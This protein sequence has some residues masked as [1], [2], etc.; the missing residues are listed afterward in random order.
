M[1]FCV[2]TDVKSEITVSV[3]IPAYNVEAFIEETLQSVVSQRGFSNFEVLVIDD[4]STDGTAAVV[5]RAAQAD[6]RIIL[7]TNGGSQGAAGARNF[8]LQRATGIW[9]AFLD[10]DD[11]WEP[12]NLALKMRAAIA[13]PHEQLISSDY[14]NENRANRTV[15]RVEWPR[16]R[17]SL[18]VGWQRNLEHQKSVQDGVRRLTGL[19]EIFIR[20]DVLGHT[21]T[22]IVKRELIEKFGGFDESL[23]V[24]EDVHLWIRIA[25]FVG[26]ML[27]VEK[28]LFF[29]RYRAG[30]LT[31]QDYPAHAFFAERLFRS[32]LGRV[33]FR[34]YKS[35]IRT[36]I[37]RALN[38]QCFYFRKSGQFVNA[39][40]SSTR[41][42]AV[43]PLEKDSWRNLAAS[44]LLR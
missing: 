38:E 15:D 23:K 2:A 10:G 34:S 41:A 28:P 6:E 44:A 18:T 35:L 14:F 43:N 8:G 1:S 4:R 7:W 31:N 39:I 29:Y 36:R 26:S 20:D 11:L 37:S 21:G 40:L 17:Q 13:W 32:L 30:S 19:A 25:E 12:D 16:L 9:I 5:K 27:L 42:L 33:E 24:G 22:F 3:I